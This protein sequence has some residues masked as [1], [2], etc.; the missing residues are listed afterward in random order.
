MSSLRAATSLNLWD[1][2]PASWY[3]FKNASFQTSDMGSWC[4]ST[5]RLDGPWVADMDAPLTLPALWPGQAESEVGT[6]GAHQKLW[7]L[8]A[9][10]V[11][12]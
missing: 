2:S 1:I 3:V 9:W 5:H 8:V 4:P 6:G 11:R 10:L 12:D 7:H